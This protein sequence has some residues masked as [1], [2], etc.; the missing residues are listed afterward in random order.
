MLVNYW[1][2]QVPRDFRLLDELEQGQKGAS[3]G[4]ISW[5]LVEED[6]MSLTNWNCMII[7]PPRVCAV[8]LM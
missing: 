5:G 3:D 7:G 6:D 4:M 2:V 8:F 1:F